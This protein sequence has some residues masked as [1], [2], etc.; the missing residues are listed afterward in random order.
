VEART[1][2]SAQ[3]FLMK[4]VFPPLWIGGFAI[5]TTT[6]F[7]A[8]TAVVDSSG[9]PADHGMKW[10]FLLVTV[11][12]T[13]FIWWSYIRLKRVR[14]DDRM[15]YV[16]NYSR[17]IAV[18]LVSVAEVK[19]NRWV[20]IHPVTIEF[21]HETE[22]GSRIVFMPKVR[23]FGFWSSHPVVEEIRTAVSRATG[24]APNG[25]T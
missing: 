11:F 6:F 20:N 1:L 7:L 8:P 18:P 21:H 14:M 24:R 15:L 19:E 23:W 13:A 16:S 9:A 3:T 10:T 12:G 5:A 4:L 2:S 17:E 22:F 25:A